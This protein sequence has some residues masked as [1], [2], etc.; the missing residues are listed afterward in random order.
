MR[1]GK[2]VLVQGYKKTQRVR[3]EPNIKRVKQLK[4]DGFCPIFD[5]FCPLFDALLSPSSRTVCSQGE[6]NQRYFDMRLPAAATLGSEGFWAWDRELGMAAEELGVLYELAGRRVSGSAE[7]EGRRRWGG[8]RGSWRRERDRGGEWRRC[9]ERPERSRRLLR[10][11][12]DG[13]GGA[14]RAPK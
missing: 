5:R 4:I 1:S 3:L 9:G 11:G 12:G 7:R 10:G 6:G 2:N 8:W 13:A 14:M